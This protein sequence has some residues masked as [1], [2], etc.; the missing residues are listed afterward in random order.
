MIDHWCR[1]NGVRNICIKA[2]VRLKLTVNAIQ[3][4]QEIIPK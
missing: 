1:E 2:I 3:L 4:N